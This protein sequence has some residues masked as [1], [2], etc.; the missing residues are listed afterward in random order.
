MAILEIR[1]KNCRSCFEAASR[2]I[3]YHSARGT[4]SCAGREKERKEEVSGQEYLLRARPCSWQ[5]NSSLF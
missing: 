4:E 2:R 1:W 3:P 5:L